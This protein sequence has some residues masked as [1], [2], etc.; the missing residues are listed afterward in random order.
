VAKK[1]RGSPRTT[2][3]IKSNEVREMEMPESRESNKAVVI[4]SDGWE[5][6]SKDL[7]KPSMLELELA[8]IKRLDWS[9]KRLC[10]E[11]KKGTVDF[12]GAVQR[13][14]VWDALRQSMLIYSMIRGKDI[15]TF[16]L[17]EVNGKYE[18]LDGLQRSTAI[19]GFMNDE[20]KL[21]A[22]TPPI[23]DVHGNLIVIAK[24][25]FGA[26]DPIIQDRI[27]SYVVRIY[28]EVNMPME[29]KINT[30]EQ[31]NNGKPVTTA[32]KNRVRVRSREVFLTLTK[33]DAIYSTIRPSTLDKRG[34]ED[35]V[36][37]IWLLCFNESS[38]SLLQSSK[39]KILKSVEVTEEQETQLVKVLDYLLAL[40]R[41][42]IEDKTMFAKMRKN[43][44]F[45][46]LG[47]LAYL[48]I[49]R[50]MAV[51]EF[52]D[53]AVAFFA[54][55]GR[56]PTT[57]SDA[58]NNACASGAAKEDKVKIRMAEIAKMLD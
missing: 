51:N 25:K 6:P 42:V 58:Y 24:Q 4:S 22:K 8:D 44:H 3:Q 30:F 37:E 10:N 27:S 12:S 56:V 23:R 54:T 13:G 40:Y 46:M 50:G 5:S 2:S 26:L 53:K 41:D 29:E 47:Y 43:T 28:Y 33:H 55:D 17:N 35:I 38:K 14:L 1:K 57:I 36:E 15:G 9:A 45:V 20:W 39:S 18:G 16:Q 34:D 21:H 31:I 19:M 7:H 11:M 48:A 52:T 32:D 49:Q